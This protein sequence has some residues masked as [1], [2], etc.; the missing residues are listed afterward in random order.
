MTLGR[1]ARQDGPSGRPAPED[2]SATLA[3]RAAG[4]TWWS[5]LEMATRY[6][7]QFLVLILLARLLSPGD[8]GLVAM[9]LVFTS[10]GTLL[11]DSGFSVALIQ[12]QRTSDDDEMTVFTFAVVTSVLITALLWL[13]AP[14]IASFYGHPKVVDLTRVLALTLP[15]GALAAVP[16]ALLTRRF[17]FKARARAE[18]LS[19]ACSCAVALWQALNGFGVW[20]LVGQVMVAAVI[21]TL[22]LWSYAAWLPRGRFSVT[23][24]RNL[25]S[26][27][28]FM[29]ISNLLDTLSTRLQSL[30]IGKLF[31]SRVV[32]YYIVAQ[33]TQEAPASLFAAV[34]NRVGL[35]VFSAIA[36]QPAKLVDGLSTSLRIAM[37]LFLPCMVGIAVIAE[38]LVVLFYGQ[39][40][41]PA[42]P[43][44][45]ILALSA[46][47]WPL[48]VLNLVALTAQGRSDLFFRL[49][50]IKKAILI[51]LI[52]L[53]SPGGA[54][55]VA[56]AVLISSLIAVVINTHYTG[57]LLGY[58]LWAQLIEQRGTVA[59]SSL[60]AFAGWLGLRLVSNGEVALLLAVTTAA[61]VYVAG[62][63]VT[64]HPALRQLSF[65]LGS[66]RSG[67]E[68]SAQ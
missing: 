63:A 35:P 68:Q 58:G 28:G 39:N 16:D 29:L 48:H 37:F 13:L 60:A 32:G 33:N 51:G 15:F 25:F 40:W 54:V 17:D 4:A 67:K 5:T 38:P 61:L 2:L 45:S 6:G 24:F 34:L 12:R 42:A 44:L 22:L 20:S 41:T 31:D 53:F 50:A 30:L 47:F 55:A 49:T 11:V 46:A 52:I 26:F 3:N 8:F 19:S 36:D 23:S 57:K 10:I 59:L 62:A 21:R 27:G 9:V 1:S 65:L 18:M 7:A 56:W 66:I 14:L 64:A 43:I